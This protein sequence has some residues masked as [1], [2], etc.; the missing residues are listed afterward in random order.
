MFIYPHKR[1]LAQRGGRGDD[2]GKWL[3]PA[4]NTNFRDRKELS[5]KF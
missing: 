5:V 3:R 4:R 2:S 1:K